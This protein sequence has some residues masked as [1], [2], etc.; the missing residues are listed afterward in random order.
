MFIIPGEFV[1]QLQTYYKNHNQLSY[2][3]GESPRQTV[4]RLVID[5]AITINN[6]QDMF[7]ISDY[8]LNMDNYNYPG[9]VDT[10]SHDYKIKHVLNNVFEVYYPIKNGSTLPTLDPYIYAFT[11]QVEGDILKISNT[12]EDIEF[13]L[14]LSKT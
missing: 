9:V 5:I 12:F 1:L 2:Y 7:S 3:S 13:L 8:E 10:W 4:S 14:P 11:V 6:N